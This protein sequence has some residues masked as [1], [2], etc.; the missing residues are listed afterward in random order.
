MLVLCIVQ[1]VEEGKTTGEK[2]R[3]E[4]KSSYKCMHF[5]QRKMFYLEKGFFFLVIHSAVKCN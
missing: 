3:L 5:G 4:A 2:C 1:K